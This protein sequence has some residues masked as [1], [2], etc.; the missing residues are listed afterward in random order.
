ARNRPG[1]WR[2]RHAPAFL[3]SH[4]MPA[5]SGR[6]APVRT[7]DNT[8][9]AAHYVSQ[10]EPGFSQPEPAP[11]PHPHPPPPPP[12][13][14]PSP[15]PPSTPPRPSGRPRRRPRATP[16][17]APPFL[18]HPDP[19]SSQPAPDTAPPAHSL[20]PPSSPASSSSVSSAPLVSSR[21][22]RT[23]EVAKRGVETTSRGKIGGETYGGDGPDLSSSSPTS[24]LTRRID[25][26]PT[27]G[28]V[29]SARV[30][31]PAARRGPGGSGCGPGGGS[32]PPPR[33]GPQAGGVWVLPGGLLT[34]GLLPLLFLGQI[35]GNPL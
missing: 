7:S 2:A 33:V 9:R 11:H 26:V 24:R 20:P 8:H 32:S 17:P 13:P 22:R 27:V 28:S 12:P 15:S 31:P 3:C 4:K 21:P 1:W 6:S 34:G 30:G 23:Y 14:P 25:C 16:P 18:P 29:H 5:R 35:N 19:A 10:P